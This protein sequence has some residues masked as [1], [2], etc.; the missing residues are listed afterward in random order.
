VTIHGSTW[1]PHLA[2]VG[3]FGVLSGLWVFWVAFPTASLRSPSFPQP[4]FPLLPH[5]LLQ[6]PPK[7][8]QPS[9]NNGLCLW[10][11]SLTAVAF[12]EGWLPPHLVLLGEDRRLEHRV[13]GTQPPPGKVLT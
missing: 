13:G 8:N 7:S 10:S 4:F 9:A 11:L 12:G 2:L 6:A 3:T 5:T 1:G